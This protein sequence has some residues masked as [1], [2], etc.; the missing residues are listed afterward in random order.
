M[1]KKKMCKIC[2]KNSV[3]RTNH[4]VVLWYFCCFVVVGCDGFLIRF[5]LRASVALLRET[6]MIARC[7]LYVG[8]VLFMFDRR[9]RHLET[10]ERRHI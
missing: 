2:N 4:I 6:M 1:F 10:P 9:G 8:P 3:T 7:Y 5:I